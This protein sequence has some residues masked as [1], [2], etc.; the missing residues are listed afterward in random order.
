[1]DQQSLQVNV[2]QW[3]SISAEMKSGQNP[4]LAADESLTD[5]GHRRM[6][7]DWTP[8]RDRA[9]AEK[10]AMVMGSGRAVRSDNP[11]SFLK[12]P[13]RKLIALEM[14]GASVYQAVE[15]IASLGKRALV[16][17]GVRHYG[18]ENKDDTFR[19]YASD[20]SAIYLFHFILHAC[21]PMYDLF[22]PGRVSDC[23]PSIAAHAIM[24]S[25]LDRSYSKLAHVRTDTCRGL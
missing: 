21:H 25:G 12:G 10:F 14:E 13:E 24:P 17:K 8:C 22:P 2:P 20:A 3:R 1:M 6:Q 11:F 18:D 9:Y 23:Q 4:L 15:T 7:G 16:V 5:E 19:E